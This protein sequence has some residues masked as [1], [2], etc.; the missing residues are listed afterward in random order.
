LLD[1]EGIMPVKKSVGKR[2]KR[3]P[4]TRKQALA[5]AK[6]AKEIFAKKREIPAAW[7]K[8]GREWNRVLGHFGPSTNR[9]SGK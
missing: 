7:K 8:G 4:L 3:S 2:P 1:K 5:A 9:S 6:A